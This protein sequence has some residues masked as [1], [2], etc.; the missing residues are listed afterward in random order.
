MPNLLTGFRGSG[1]RVWPA[2]RNC[3]VLSE[4]VDADVPVRK[5]GDDLE[6]TTHRLGYDHMAA[7]SAMRRFGHANG[8]ARSLVTGLWPSLD[9]LPSTERA[10]TGVRLQ[11]QKVRI[12]IK[13]PSLARARPSV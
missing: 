7:A 11:P 2:L 5:P 13:Q 6:L 8:Y 4:L 3:R 1:M 10:A 9:V 12:P